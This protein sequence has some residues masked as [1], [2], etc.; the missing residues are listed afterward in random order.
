MSY[1]N[2]DC[3][4]K[5]E[6][7]L[8]PDKVIQLD[9]DK[10]KLMLFKKFANDRKTNNYD[11]QNWYFI[12]HEKVNAYK[13]VNKKN[14]KVLVYDASKPKDVSLENL[15]YTLKH[16]GNNDSL[17]WYWRFDMLGDESF[18]IRNLGD[19]NKVLNVLDSKGKDGQN[20]IISDDKHLPS[21]RFKFIRFK[22]RDD[23]TY[24]QVKEL[25]QPYIQRENTYNDLE[26]LKLKIFSS[27]QFK[28]KWAHIAHMLGFNWCYGTNGLYNGDDL[29]IKRVNN[30]YILKA[31]YRSK[32]PFIGAFKPEERLEIEISD[33][34]LTFDPDSIIPD[35]PLIKNLSPTLVSNT[36]AI[37]NH[38]QE[39]N[40]LTEIGYTESTSVS[41]SSS[42]SISNSIGVQNSFNIKIHGV[43]FQQQFTYNITHQ[44]TWGQQVEKTTEAKSKYTYSTTVAPN[45][46]VPIYAILYR[47]Q[48][49][50]PYKAKANLEYSIRFKGIL[51]AKNALKGQPT[52]R[53]REAYTFGSK[54][55]PATKA[56]YD[57]YLARN[58]QTS[59]KGW[60]YEWCI[61]NYDADY[62]N[63]YMNQAITP[64]KVEISG[65]F[66]NI[67]SNNVAIVA[68]KKPEEEDLKIKEETDADDMHE[69]NIRIEIEKI[70]NKK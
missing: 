7:N 8:N 43:K 65:I 12:A 6:T 28:K 3:I 34:R 25:K 40:I 61:L 31:N 35:K 32:D 14:N 17:S 41:N 70:E 56:L 15:D 64:D 4:Y 54:D 10:N 62:F 46:Q 26:D 33:I 19:T 2:K 29:S 37:N 38:N 53:R 42:N 58:A 23:Y 45:S 55:I 68:G 18:I 52:D 66:T 11:N 27:D 47:S 20:I 9:L 51:K 44:K 13:I 60:D 49:S 30:K 39:G 57:E 59:K 67:Y 5:I 16:T 21:Q 50:I 69:K 48:A 1:I 24:E 22:F 36:T 63:E